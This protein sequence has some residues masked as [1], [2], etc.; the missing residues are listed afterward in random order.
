MKGTG[1]C[2]CGEVRIL[3]AVVVVLIRPCHREKRCPVDADR[4]AVA[5]RH[6]TRTVVRH[7]FRELCL[8]PL[9]RRMIREIILRQILLFGVLILREILRHIRQIVSHARHCRCPAAGIEPRARHD[10]EAPLVRLVLCGE[11]DIF[12]HRVTYER[13]EFVPIHEP[14]V[15]VEKAQPIELRCRL[16]VV[17]RAVLADAVR[18]LVPEHGGKLVHISAETADKP[19]VYAHIV[20]RVTGGIEDGAVRHRPCKGQRVHAEHVVAVPHEPLHN[21][22]HQKDRTERRVVRAEHAERLCRN[23]PRINRLCARRRENDTC[24]YRKCGK[25]RT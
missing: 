17:V 15:H 5:H 20:R 7:E 6:M 2:T 21:P 1:E 10:A 13:I 3:G 12:R 25:Y 4:L 23:P 9:R 11:R 14:K 16:R 24:R 8:T 18:H 22:V 19:A